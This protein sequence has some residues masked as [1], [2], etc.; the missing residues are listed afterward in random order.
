MLQAQFEQMIKLCDEREKLFRG[1]LRN[2]REVREEATKQLQA[3]GQEITQM[4]EDIRQAEEAL[5]QQKM[6][7]EQLKKLLSQLQ[8]EK[9]NTQRRRQRA[10]RSKNTY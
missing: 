3:K 5:M 4:K 10:V 9:E 1:K 7:V 6:K 2:I 8:C